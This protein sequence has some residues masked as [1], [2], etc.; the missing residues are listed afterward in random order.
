MLLDALFLTSI[1]C[2]NLVLNKLN[3]YFLLNE[4]NRLISLLTSFE[5]GVYF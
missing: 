3:S 2:T 4:Q 1:F 5:T